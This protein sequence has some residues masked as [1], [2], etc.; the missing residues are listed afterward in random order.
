MPEAV[1]R[2][3]LVVDDDPGV[4]TVTRGL[5]ASRGWSVA[6]ADGAPAALLALGAGRFDVVLL[7]L[8]M[9]GTSGAALLARLRALHPG[10][11]L[12]VMS[13]AEASSGAI[14]RDDAFVPKPF[15]GDALAHALAQAIA[16]QRPTAPAS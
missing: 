10:L 6:E 11:A 16:R 13:G 8:A 1:S 3:V 7:D 15:S 9:P 5:L 12:V 4:R 2:R 14:G